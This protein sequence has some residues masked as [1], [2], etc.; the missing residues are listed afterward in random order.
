MA[1]EITL[2]IDTTKLEA[3]LKDLPEKLAK[4]AMRNA[5]QAGGDVMLEAMIAAAPERTDEPTPESNSLPPGVL[6]ADLHTE[7]KMSKGSARVKVGPSQI[8]GHVARW[9]NNGWVL[10]G[11]NPGKKEIREIPGTHFIE[12]AFD[13][14]A[15]KAIDTAIQALSD[16]LGKE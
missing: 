4:K 9:I 11:H 12:R 14:S 5:L 7:I 16:A 13:E 1:D 6:K 8:T 2:N 3:A 10:T 15:Q